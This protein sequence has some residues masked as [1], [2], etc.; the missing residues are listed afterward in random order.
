M[1]FSIIT[2]NIN[3]VRIR[4]EHLKDI[5]DNYKPDLICLQETKVTNDKFPRE[6]I[7]LLGYD[8]CYPNGIPSYNGVCIISKDKARN[9]KTIN[10]CGT[11]D[12]RHIQLQI[13]NLT[14]HNFYIPAGGDE[15]VPETNMKFKHK[16]CFLNELIIWAKKQNTNNTILCG[17]FNIAPMKNDVWS[18]NQLKNSISHT[19][20]EREK[21][22][23]FQKSGC[24]LDIVK[25][26]I[27]P[28]NN[29]FTW[30]SYRSPNFKVNNRGRRLDHIWI[31]KNL[32]QNV[33]DTKILC[34]YRGLVKPSDH[35][36]ILVRLKN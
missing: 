31:S 8:Y 4:L 26:K 36:P 22:I 18:H 3:S 30:W 25:E 7:K 11:N 24:W 6:K 21:L 32:K 10:W 19:R 23:E 17:D 34:K 20:I 27:L 5:V 13:K 12:G 9:V 33:L 28:P 15:P 35:V 29:I 16:I 2:W 14:L 1:S